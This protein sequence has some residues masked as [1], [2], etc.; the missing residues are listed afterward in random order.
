MK[1]SV[2]YVND[3]GMGVPIASITH[4]VP[5]YQQ[6]LNAAMQEKVLS[7]R[8]N[9]LPP[10]EFEVISYDIAAMGPKDQPPGS[11]WQM[12]RSMGAGPKAAMSFDP[13]NP[14]LQEMIAKAV[15]AAVAAIKPAAGANV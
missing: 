14:A 2:L 8:N 3:G 15:A 4:D 1:Q 13:N 10:P 7:C 5:F 11:K 9:G 6:H 12:I